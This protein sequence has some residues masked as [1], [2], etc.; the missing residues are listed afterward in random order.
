DV[1]SR[2]LPQFFP[3]HW[4][5]QPGLV[6]SEFPSRI[7]IG[8][9]VRG[10]GNYSYLCDEEFSGLSATLEEVHAAALEN[11]AKLPSAQLS[12][13]KVPGGA[14]GW[15]HAT[16]D[17]F[18]AARILCRR[19]SKYSAGSSGRSFSSRFLTAMIVFVGARSKLRNGKKNTR[20]MH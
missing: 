14:E 2:V 12:I 1:I 8:Y 20:R 4:L 5:N 10:E 6:F 18:A 17:N 7:R 13:G 11:L 9:V 16:E 3:A 19:S 15:I